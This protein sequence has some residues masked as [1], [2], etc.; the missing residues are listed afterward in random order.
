MNAQK[1]FLGKKDGD[2]LIQERRKYCESDTSKTGA[3]G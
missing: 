3:D 1:D 2:T